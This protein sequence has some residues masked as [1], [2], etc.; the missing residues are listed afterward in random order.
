MLGSFG[1]TVNEV[2]SA[3]HRC[4]QLAWLLSDVKKSGFLNVYEDWL[5]F[6]LLRV[7]ELCVCFQNISEKINNKERLWNAGKV[8]MIV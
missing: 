3:S 8:M 6:C 5:E 2:I 1:N 4:D 7:L